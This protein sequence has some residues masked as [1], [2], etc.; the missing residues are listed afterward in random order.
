MALVFI[1]FAWLS[2]RMPVLVAAVVTVGG[3]AKYVQGAGTTSGTIPVYVTNADVQYTGSGAS[4]ISLQ[5]ATADRIPCV[6]A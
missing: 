4:A 2:R 3:G 5:G 1:V 6:P